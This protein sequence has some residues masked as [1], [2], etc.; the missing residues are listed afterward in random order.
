MTCVIRI[1][2][3]SRSRSTS[4]PSSPKQLWEG[5]HDEPCI[6]VVLQELYVRSSADHGVQVP[7]LGGLVEYHV[8]T[9]EYPS[10]RRWCPDLVQA[11]VQHL[12]E[13]LPAFRVIWRRGVAE[14]D[15]CWMVWDVAI[16]ASRMMTLSSEVIWCPTLSLAEERTLGI[17]LQY[18][19]WRYQ[20]DVLEVL[21]CLQLPQ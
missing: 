2:I 3:I 11:I 5:P 15:S 8:T 1:Q 14:V 18:L 19:R 12:S 6:D 20:D 17:H 9:H 16:L 7:S 13:H 10:F 4:S 21:Q